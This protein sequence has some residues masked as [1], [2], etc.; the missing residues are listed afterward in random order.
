[1]SKSLGDQLAIICP[2]P[3]IAVNR[4][5][6]IT[7]FNPAAEN[8]LGY[9]AQDAIGALNI[10]QIY[11]PPA[12]GRDVKRLMYDKALGGTG[13]IKG[14]ESAMKTKD[15]NIVPIQISATLLLEDDNEVGSIGFFHDLSFRKEL[16][17]TLKQQS[18][19]D[20]LSG[21]YNQRHFR[22]TLIKEIARC[23]RYKHPLALACLDLDNFKS[24]NDQLGHIIGD[25]I[26]SFMGQI[27]RDEL[28]GCDFGF[29]YGGDEFML[30]LPEAEEDQ[31]LAV[32]KRLLKVF[33]ERT[34]LNH[35]P[36]PP[37]VS[38]S[39]GITEFTPGEG[40]EDLFKRADMAMYQAK[41]DGGNQAIKA[42]K[43]E[44]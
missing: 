26:I 9:A 38:I 33:S 4:A 11:H 31:A 13:Q 17:Q 22:S 37:K 27:I 42:K 29:R 16:E 28:R 35:M 43:V 30:I 8:L 2:E 36:A 14:H 1:M 20:S 6:M 34:P 3:I 39:I 32:A 12:A 7:L 41:K 21:L 40:P 15:G 18:I 5:G 25:S 10:S 44:D 24:V 23:N 19:T